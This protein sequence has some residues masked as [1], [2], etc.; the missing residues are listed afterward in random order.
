VNVNYTFT[1][2]P[3][4]NA[5]VSNIGS[6]SAALFD[7]TI[8][9]GNQ[10]IQGVPGV[11]NMTAGP[12]GSPGTAATVNVNYTFTGSPGTNALVSNIGSTSAALF[13]FTIPRGTT[14]LTGPMNQTPN[15]TANM[16]QGPQGIP[17]PNTWDD[18]WNLTYPLLSGIRMITGKWNFGGFN[19]SNVGDPFVSSDVATKNYADLLNTSMRNNVSLNF[20]SSDSNFY[21]KDTSRAITGTLIKRDVDSSVLTIAG[22]TGFS[23]GQGSWL[24]LTGNKSAGSGNTYFGVPNGNNGYITV[25]TIADGGTPYI[26]ANTYPIKDL[27]DPSASQ[28]AATKNY[29]DLVNTSMNNVQ[30]CGIS[31]AIADGGTITH[32]LGRTPVYALVSGTNSSQIEAVTSKGGTTI[33][34][35]L[36]KASTL[37]VGASDTISWC[38]G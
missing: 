15:M 33:T 19:I 9:R 4:T 35:S 20:L 2:S 10:G 34:V 31:G 21:Y 5:L 36:K 25:M 12:S 13:D 16:T 24:Q 8:P 27:L 37:A 6:T 7:F 30:K 11:A 14:G 29:V 28:D 22:G 32:G 18:S 3:G 17:G 23:A 26:D 1:G 38:V